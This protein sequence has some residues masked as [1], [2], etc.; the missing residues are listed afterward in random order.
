MSLH[1]FSKA[2]SSIFK[3]GKKTDEA[4]PSIPTALPY[5]DSLNMNRKIIYNR[6]DPTQDIY[7]IDAQQ[8]LHKLKRDDFSGLEQITLVTGRDWRTKKDLALW[9]VWFNNIPKRPFNA[10]VMTASQSYGALE[11][12]MI[13]SSSPYLDYT[14]HT[15]RVHLNKISEN[16]IVSIGIYDSGSYLTYV[17][18]YQI[19]SM[20][21]VINPKDNNNV[22]L[23][24]VNLNLL[25]AHQ[26][27]SV[28]NAKT[29][30]LNDD[31]YSDN[32][33]GLV[34]W[35]FNSVNNITEAY[36]WKPHFLP[37]TP[38]SFVGGD[39]ED[40]FKRLSF[41]LDNQGLD[42]RI[43]DAERRSIGHMSI[44][45]GTYDDFVDLCRAAY[46]EAKTHYDNEKQVK[47]PRDRTKDRDKTRKP[48]PVV[49]LP[50]AHIYKYGDT[51]TGSIMVQGLYYAVRFPTES[52][53]SR[54]GVET[55]L[56]NQDLVMSTIM[57]NNSV[58]L[59]SPNL[60]E[61]HDV[62]FRYLTVNF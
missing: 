11:Q 47:L 31:K 45:D 22:S 34:E 52:I 55:Y 7:S 32:E 29:V 28:G 43:L 12:D 3:V 10:V 1:S 37:F 57:D 46:T 39:I 36:P 2:P 27:D 59:L 40:R 16:D 5:D 60:V 33:T 6:E 4:L 56:S 25:R 48:K 23:P 62:V 15:S 41:V 44:Q 19:V 30:E 35:V 24:A 8:F 51:I 20:C 49:N 13:I 21:N 61:N 38:N 14:K 50:L 9:D 26:I 54:F 17:M 53:G 58:L 42:A 18:I